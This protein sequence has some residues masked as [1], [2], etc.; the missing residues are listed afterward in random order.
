MSSPVRAIAHV[1]RPVRSLPSLFF[2]GSCYRNWQGNSCAD[3]TCPFDLAFVDIP[4]GDLNMD[5]KLDDEI[6]TYGAQINDIYAF[7]VYPTDGYQINRA[8]TD[9]SSDDVMYTTLTAKEKAA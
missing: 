5:G 2:A 3:R 4:H 1:C 9:A 6:T 8:A 7:E